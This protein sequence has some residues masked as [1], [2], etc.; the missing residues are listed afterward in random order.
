WAA[1]PAGP[2]PRLP[3]LSSP[4]P[5]GRRGPD[6]AM[7]RTMSSLSY[8]QAIVN[9]SA[10]DI[11]KLS[12]IHRAPG[13]QRFRHPPGLGDAADR[14]V[15]RVALQQLRDAAQPGVA[16][17]VLQRPQQRPPGGRVAAHPRPRLGVGAQQ[18]GPGGALVVGLVALALRARVAAMVARIA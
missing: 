18:P 2:S 14:A 16:Q 6:Y 10:R 8:H 7:P 5:R 3:S 4:P 13:T 9:I 12:R 1:R 15:R 17:V 11:K